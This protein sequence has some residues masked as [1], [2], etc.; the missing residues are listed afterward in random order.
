MLAAANFPGREIEND[1]AAAPGSRP[2][3]GARSRTVQ[4]LLHAHPGLQG[5]RAGPR[6][7]RPFSVHRR[8]RQHARPVPMREPGRGRYR[9]M[10]TSPAGTGLASGIWPS[11]WKPRTTSGMPTSPCRRPVSPSCARSTMSARRASISTI[12]TGISRDRLGT[13]RC[14]GNIRPGPRR[15]GQASHFFRLVGRLVASTGAETTARPAL[16]W[17][18]RHPPRRSTWPIFMR[19]TMV[20]SSRRSGRPS[21]TKSTGGRHP[22]SVPAAGPAR[23]GREGVPDPPVA[24]RAREVLLLRGLQRRG[25]VRR[26]ISRPITSRR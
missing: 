4:G 20:S 24:D 22:A 25:G 21:P 2:H 11:R 9:R 7:R 18:S 1:Q 6:A 10:P 23:A 3:L 17:F 19:S 14:A 15:R 13:S 5:P 26:A 8:S 16:L 12:P